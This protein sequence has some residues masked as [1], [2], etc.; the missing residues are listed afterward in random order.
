MNPALEHR[1]SLVDELLARQAEL[2]TAVMRFSDWHDRHGEE[3]PAQRQYYKKLIPMGKPGAGQQ[4]AFEVNLDQ[5][6][7]CKACV[8]AC[9]SLNGL[10]EEESWRDVGMLVGTRR[11]PYVQTITTA[12]H[13]CVDPAC[14]NG[15][16]VLAYEKDALTGIVKHLDDQCIGCSYCMMKCPYDVPKWN[17]NK[18]IVRKCDMCSQR[19]AVGEAPACVQAC[20]SEAISIRIVEKDENRKAAMLPQAFR[21]SYTQPTTRYVSE[22]EI[23]SE[24]R[25]PGA[26]RL[27]LEEAHWPLAWML[28]L[29]QMATGLFGV[30][31]WM[32]VE[33]MAWLSR[34]ALAVLGVGIGLSVLHLGQ[35]TRA[36]RCFLGLRKSWLSREIVVFG[37]FMKVGLLAAILPNFWT[38]GIAMLIGVVGVFCSVMVYADTQRLF[39]GPGRT[40][41]SF[42]GTTLLLGT[43]GGGAVLSWMEPSELI[44]HLGIAATVIRTLLFARERMTL[45]AALQDGQ[46]WMRRPARTMVELKPGVLLAGAWLFGLSTLLGLIGMMNVM[47]LGMV[48]A[49]ASFVSTLI[50]QVLTRHL[51]FV[52]VDAPRMVS[53]SWR[54]MH[55]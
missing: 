16:P 33:G 19:L 36:W 18:G 35:P 23:P 4:Y 24:A 34:L 27:K 25:D 7:G 3:A 38:A 43:T 51:F 45:M 10:D 5:C 39:W 21:S 29:T 40:M 15:C 9:H 2:G 28:V 53:T 46:H 20:P 41:W 49:T 8:A 47:G 22:R 1:V 52:A 26:S 55:G 12:C 31:M 32:P 14:S 50:S 54:A 37:G 17:A 30:A 6:T 13:H 42:F 11:K 48:W 44:I